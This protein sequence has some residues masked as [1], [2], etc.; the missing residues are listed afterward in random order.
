MLITPSIINMIKA[1][2][3]TTKLEAVISQE[4]FEKLASGMLKM[5][6]GKDGN[7]IPTLRDL[8]TKK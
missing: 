1:L 5:H 6:I 4:D 7:I 3:P 8:I 2:I